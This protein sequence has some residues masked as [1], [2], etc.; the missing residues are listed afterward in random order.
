MNILFV[1]TGNTCRSPMAAAMFQARTKHNVQ[2][3]GIFASYGAPASAHTM[4][5]LRENNITYEHSS[6]PVTEELLDWA[7]LVL[8]MTTQHRDMLK[9][10]YPHYT[11]TI[12][13]LKEYALPDFEEKWNE[14]TS[15]YAQLETKKLETGTIDESIK[16]K[17]IELEKD[18]H[19]ID[20]SDPFGGNLTLYKKTYE[21]LHKHLALLEK[22]LQYRDR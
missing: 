11:S 10:Q 8:T 4:E 14:L 1:C 21:D 15:L 17:I 5:I 7:D 19:S 2:S 18:I 22:K 16:A 13:A 20:I 9:Q 12:F 3:A 6:Q